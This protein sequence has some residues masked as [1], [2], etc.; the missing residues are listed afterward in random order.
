MNDDRLDALTEPASR[1]PD[2]ILKDKPAPLRIEITARTMVT[3][4]VVVGLS[5]L[6]L[7]LA[8]V[9]LVVIVALFLVGTLSP[10]V[11]WLQ[12]RRMKR[13]AAIGVIFAALLL[14]FAGLA[15]LTVPALIAQV[16]TFVDQEPVVRSHVA[17]LLSTSRLTAPLAEA[18]RSLDYAV[19]A[20]SSAGAALDMSEESV[21]VLAYLASAVFLAL[22][23]MIDRD[24]LRGGLY[25][26][27]PRTHH[28]RLSR[29]LLN[30]EVIVGGYIRGQVVTSALMAVF[31]FVLLLICGV[32]GA[33]AVA[34]IAGV[35]D[36]LP[37]VG[38]F[39]SVGL[40]LA[41]A[42]PRGPFVLGIVLVAMLV[43]E[44]LES[45]VL[46][47]RIYGNV[48]KLPSSMVLLALLAG[49][50]LMGIPGALL[51]LPVAAAIRMLVEELRVELPGEETGVSAVRD[52]DTRAEEEYQRRAHGVPVE[53]AAAI[54]VA[55]SEQRQ[56]E[57][58]PLS[59]RVA[60][61]IVSAQTDKTEE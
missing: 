33:L 20:R 41:A 43:Y 49:G 47:P 22:Y 10:A 56:S 19:L 17:D 53:T 4:A 61:I 58:D 5:L 45:R 21:E 36:V 40:A 55:I 1:R 26:V 2:A 54:A 38:V 34:V 18:L 14:G 3:A 6:S 42:L 24:R 27:V 28:I 35:A 12:A 60:Q 57:V 48:L 15:A 8:P 7:R 39:I 11:A 31:T 9:V 59:E 51:A 44:E 30:L 13:G 32:K 23:M 25:A 37:Y 52:E 29:V 46:V 50:T 16:M